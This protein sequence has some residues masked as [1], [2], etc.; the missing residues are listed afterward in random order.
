VPQGQTEFI[1]HT[2]AFTFQSTAYECFIVNQGGTNAQFKGVGTST[3]P[4]RTKFMLWASDGDPDT[5]RYQDLDKYAA[6]VRILSTTTAHWA[7]ALKMV[8]R[9]RAAALSSTRNR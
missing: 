7:P 2:R 3:A 1:F 4:A 6:A 5:F 9:C 8:S